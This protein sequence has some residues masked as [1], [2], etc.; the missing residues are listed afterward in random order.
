MLPLAR[1]EGVLVER[2]TDEVVV[3]DVERDD[4]HCLNH[5]AAWLWQ[6][7]DG[8][9]TVNDLARDAAAALG[10]PD[11]PYL[12]W[13]AL[14]ELATA[15]LLVEPARRDRPSSTMTRREVA[16]RL[17]LVGAGLALALPLI[18]TI[19]APTP[20]EASSHDLGT[21]APFGSCTTSAQC[22]DE[23]PCCRFGT[24]MNGGGPLC[25]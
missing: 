18:T 19:A 21:V 7:C 14:D 5:V 6:R 4:V 10:I 9:T 17:G 13:L 8:A 3:Y 1:T 12:V 11:D 23:F 22:T 25:S 15:R 20:L 2:L 24:C 16:H